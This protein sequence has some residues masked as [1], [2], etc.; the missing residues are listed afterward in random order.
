MEPRTVRRIVYGV[1]GG[2]LLVVAGFGGWLAT[3]LPW[4]IPLFES[5]IDSPGLE[6]PVRVLPGEGGV[7]TIQAETERDAYFAMGYVH[8]RDRF[9]QMESMRRFGAGRLAEVLGPAAVASDKWMRTLG[10]YRLARDAA[11]AL[12][13]GTRAALEPMRRVSITG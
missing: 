8:A 9:W 1:V 2:V 5:R 4:Q 12:P 3:S 10:L 6:K 13:E 7:P 11:E